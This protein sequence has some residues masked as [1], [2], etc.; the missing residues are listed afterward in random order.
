MFNDDCPGAGLNSCI[1][2]NA[3]SGDALTLPSSGT[4]RIEATSYVQGV[5]GSYSLNLTLAS[6][7]QSLV[8]NKTGNGGGAV[9]SN[10]SGIDCGGDCTEDYARGTVVTLA[11]TPSAGS[12]FSG[13]SGCDSFLANSCTVTMN[14]PRTI[15]ALFTTPLVLGPL[16]LPKGEVNLPYNAALVGGGVAPYNFTILKG[17]L[18]PGLIGDAWSGQLVGM[19][20]LSKSGNVTMN[21]TDQLGSSVKGTFKMTVVGA[22][23]ISTA[24]LKTGTHGNVYKGLLKAQGGSAPY[25]WSLMEGSLPT[26]MTLNTVTGAL[27]GTPTQTGSFNPRFRVTDLLGGSASHSFMLTIN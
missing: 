3:V 10:P 22:L 27:T 19:P 11:A 13:W 26:G 25:A 9:T 2:I 15:T 23:N 16:T 18:P 5:T 7:P 17:V 14:T 20:A 4:Y 12:V 24:S 21:I 8:L 1:P 6:G